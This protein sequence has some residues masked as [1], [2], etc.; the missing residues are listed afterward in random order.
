MR[1]LLS[2]WRHGLIA[3]TLRQSDGGMVQ[4]GPFAGRRSP[5]RSTEGC[6]DHEPAQ[7]IEALR[8]LTSLV[9]CHAVLR[10]GLSGRIAAG[11]GASHAVTRIDHAIR[12]GH[13]GPTP[14]LLPVPRAPD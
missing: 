6:D 9:D 14:W 8:C 12:E 11:F 2:K 3:N 4:S 10:F 13:G 1:R 5:A 7:T